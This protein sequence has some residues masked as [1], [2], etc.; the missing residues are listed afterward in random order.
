MI[1]EQDQKGSNS[2]LQVRIPANRLV[3][4]RPVHLGERGHGPGCVED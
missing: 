3:S 4:P 1:P 2:V